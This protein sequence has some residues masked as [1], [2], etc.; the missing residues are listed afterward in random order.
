MQEWALWKRIWR[1]FSVL[2]HKKYSVK[3]NRSNR[4]KETSET[5]IKWASEVF[6]LLFK[7]GVSFVALNYI[8]LS[9]MQIHTVFYFNYIIYSGLLIFC[10]QNVAT[11]LLYQRFQN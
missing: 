2:T 7:L 3:R 6:C 8:S 9:F 5:L 10:C 4:H 11:F 1:S